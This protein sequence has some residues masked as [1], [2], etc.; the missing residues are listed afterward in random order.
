MPVTSLHI[1]DVGP[2][3]AI[4]FEFD[5]QVNVITGPNNS[6]K[7]TLLWVLG[8]L[9]VYPFTMPG[10][11][12]RSDRASWKLNF[13]NAA[14]T[15]S[16]EGKFPSDAINMVPLYQKVG[17]T[18]YV[19]A[20]RVSTNYRSTGPTVSRYLESRIDESFDHVAAEWP[21][22][23][24]RMGLEGYRQAVRQELVNESNP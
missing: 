14:V 3:E 17:Y 13:S 18:S 21:E 6:G 12:I 19:P 7:S 20:Q 24:T 22:I 15:E 4:T 9:L 8:E 2:F 10:R 5:R 23:V 1:T 16:I 11:A